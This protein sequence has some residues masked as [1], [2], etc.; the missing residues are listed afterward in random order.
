MK[1]LFLLPLLAF[2]LVSCSSP[3]TRF[4]PV[5]TAPVHQSIAQADKKIAK[6]Q[7]RVSKVKTQLAKIETRVPDMKDAFAAARNELDLLTQDLLAA[8]EQNRET[9][10][11][12]K[13]ADADN[14]KL[15]EKANK[16]GA[17]LKV[18]EERQKLIDKWFGIGAILYGCAKLAKNVLILVAFLMLAI[19]LLAMLGKV[20]PVLGVPFEIASAYLVR[21]IRRQ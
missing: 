5:S 21:K 13:Q 18:L 14:L 6:A 1:S 9:G 20:F 17:R 4:R 8:R 7:G 10:E 3:K 11:A 12:L 16:M 2:C 19:S 15:V